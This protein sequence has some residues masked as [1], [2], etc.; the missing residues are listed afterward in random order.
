MTFRVRT[1]LVVLLLTVVT[2]GGAFVAVWGRFV[3]TRR[4]QL[5]EALLVVARRAATRRAAGALEFTDAPGPFA[6][7]VTLPRYAVYYDED[8]RPLSKTSNLATL[9]SLPP[10]APLE[11][12]FDF[13]H[14]GIVMRGVL[15]AVG[16]AGRRLLIAS[17][18]GNL[19]E[20]AEALAHVMVIAFVAGCAWAAAVAFGVAT[21]LTRE[22]QIIMDVA[23]RVASGDVSA[24]V[25]FRASDVDLRQLA[26]DLNAMIEQLVGLLAVQERFIAHAAHELRTPLTSLQL[27][28]EHAIQTAR[29]PTDYDT[30]LRGALESARRLTDLAED[31]LQ[32]ARLNAAPT[33]EVTPIEEA[34]AAA[35]ADVGPVGRTREVVIVTEL[36]S[37]S[38]RGDRRGL[39]RLLRNVL[40][41]AVRYSPRG[42]KVRVEGHVEDGHVVIGVT[43]EGPGI[44]PADAERIFEPFTRGV[45][46]DG[47]A[48]T[49]LGL[50]I[51]RGLARSLGGDVTVESG[52]GGRF[53]IELP[54]RDSSPGS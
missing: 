13:E 15:L 19:E 21:R 35:V 22:H 9:P 32:L 30:A 53:F 29:T 43:D 6:N 49:G 41:N 17:P 27:E 25:A 37:A 31:L 16:T 11:R 51:A 47:P 24:R 4:A 45:R 42:G 26:S 46:D 33:E 12:G 38:V 14:D 36:T 23:R 8:G 2:L 54:R 28:L 10:A 48:G 1:A 39:I 44:A 40:E 20:D 3:S 52:P 18:R 34:L 7:S 5:D 50:S